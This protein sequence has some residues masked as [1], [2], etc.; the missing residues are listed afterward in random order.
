MEVTLRERA[1]RFLARREHSR[2]ELTRKLGKYAESPEQLDALLDELHSRR[3]LSDER[4]SEMRV[5]ARAARYGNARLA[6]ELRMQGVAEE[7]V[8]AALAAE[9]DEL[10]RA[11]QVWCRKFGDQPEA[12]D[13]AARARQIRFMMSRG[14]SGETIRRVMHGDFE[15]G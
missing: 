9:E 5:H 3:L 11:R 8:E 14:F 12:P 15:N 7:V 6:Q 1:L 2:L 4:Y 13:A 10:S